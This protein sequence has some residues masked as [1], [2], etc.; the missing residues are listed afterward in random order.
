MLWTG[1]T[2]CWIEK[3]STDAEESPDIDR[4]GKAKGQGDVHQGL[5]VHR[6]GAEEVVGSLGPCKGEE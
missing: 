5:D 1:T 4:Q 3:P 6:L 2:Y